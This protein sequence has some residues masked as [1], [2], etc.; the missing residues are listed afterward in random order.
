MCFSVQAVNYCDFRIKHYVL[1]F[2]YHDKFVKHEIFM[3]G[4]FSRGR[5]ADMPFIWLYAYVSLEIVMRCFVSAIKCTIN[6]GNIAYPEHK[7][8]KLQGV[9]S[10]FVPRELKEQN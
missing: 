4:P 6:I 8:K 9:S 2:I 10:T 1:D 3:S 5:K 7:R